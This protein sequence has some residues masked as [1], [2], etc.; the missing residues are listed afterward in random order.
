L[1]SDGGSDLIRWN[2][3]LGAFTV[4]S[5]TG[6][7][8]G[9]VANG[10]VFKAQMIGTTITVFKN[11]VQ[12]MTVSDAT[13]ATGNPGIGSFMRGNGNVLASMGWQSIVAGNL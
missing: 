3:G 5:W 9:G 4:L 11:T 7:G 12:I 1:N 6:S 2:G 10:D 8:A 13:F